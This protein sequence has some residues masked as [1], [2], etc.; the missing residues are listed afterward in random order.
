MSSHP[1][2]ILGRNIKQER[3]HQNMTQ[4]QL[5]EKVGI[6][7][8]FLSQI[9]N[10]RKVPSL[11]TVYKIAS[12]LGITMEKV[13]QGDYVSTPNIDQRI[14]V[15]L[16]DKS[17]REKQVLFDIMNYIAHVKWENIEASSSEDED[18]HFVAPN[19]EVWINKAD[20]LEYTKNQ[21]NSSQ[22]KEQED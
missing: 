3:I 20:W 9:E 19:G 16:R 11:E 12:C 17:E 5:S 4:E 15:L 1:F 14:E 2:E 7:A 8:V 6:S 22:I 18:G 21:M 10:N 13:F